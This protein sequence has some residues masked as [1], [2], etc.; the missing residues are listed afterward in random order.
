MAGDG[1]CAEIVERMQKDQCLPEDFP[2]VKAPRLSEGPSSCSPERR[3]S[4]GL[5]AGRVAYLP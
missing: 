1:L 2:E 3:V 4:G 5:A